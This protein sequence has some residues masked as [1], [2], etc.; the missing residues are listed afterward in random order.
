MVLDRCRREGTF[1]H[2]PCHAIATS[3]ILIFD[4][5]ALSTHCKDCHW[6]DY[7]YESSNTSQQFDAPVFK[8]HPLLFLRGAICKYCSRCYNLFYGS[9]ILS[10]I[11]ILA[12]V[13]ICFYKNTK[14]AFDCLLHCKHFLLVL[15]FLGE[16]FRRRFSWIANL[17]YR[18][19]FNASEY[20]STNRECFTR[21]PIKDFALCCYPLCWARCS[22][23]YFW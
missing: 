7:N 9:W 22:S 18:N 20:F 8:A 15:T 2:H 17:R 12:I 21:C 23:S 16:S 1:F 10:F 6:Q 4:T 19:F 5:I 14:E 11:A 13:F 3:S